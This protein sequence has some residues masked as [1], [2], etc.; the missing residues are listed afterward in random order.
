MEKVKPLRAVLIPS[1][2]RK[3]ESIKQ[4][5]N[6]DYEISFFKTDLVKIAISELLENT[7][8]DNDLETLLEK[9]NYI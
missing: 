6:I 9:Y 8:N 4:K 3:L 7:S 1:Q 2:N 5:A